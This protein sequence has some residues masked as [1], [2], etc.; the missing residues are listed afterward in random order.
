MMVNI[1]QNLSDGGRRRG[2]GDGD[3]D[4][5][6]FIVLDFSTAK[7]SQFPLLPSKSALE[8]FFSPSSLLPALFSP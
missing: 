6:I 8:I 3:G 4:Y 2:D 1:T 7:S 5:M